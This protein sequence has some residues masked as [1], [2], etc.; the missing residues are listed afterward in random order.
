AK[1]RTASA[2]ARYGP[3]SR[4][5]GRSGKW[6]THAIRTPSGNITAVYLD[7]KATPSATP[8]AHHQPSDVRV[9]GSVSRARMSA[10][11]IVAA[12]AKSGASGVAS[13]SPAAA[14]GMTAK[15]MAAS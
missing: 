13:T 2:T 6:A 14:S 9:R 10:Y 8:A 15:A 12:A 5:L 7:A 11:H 1:T 4:S 3:G